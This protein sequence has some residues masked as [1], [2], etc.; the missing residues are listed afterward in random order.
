MKIDYW[1]C[2]ESLKA[3]TVR[4]H[5][6][7]S[8]IRFLKSVFFNRNFR[9]I[10]TMRFCQHLCMSRG[11]ARALLLL[12]RLLHAWTQ[13]CAGLD[14]SW[15]AFVGAGLCITHGWGL[16]VSPG[17][18]IGCNVTIFHGATI[19]RADRIGPRNERQ[20]SY[21]TIEDCVWIGPHAII[22]GGVTIGRGARIAGGSFVF[23]NVEPFSLVG[24]NP[25][26]VLRKNAEP[27]V[28]NPADVATKR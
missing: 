17:A 9:V 23:R 4:L 7:Y 2:W 24:G 11:P 3:D 22:V 15:R 28:P 14:F 18:K 5:G 1:P 19:G 13:N 27:V 25:M 21:P 6:Q 8:F 20:T 12:G 16:V 10:L 26:R